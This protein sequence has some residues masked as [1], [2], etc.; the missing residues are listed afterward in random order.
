MIRRFD[1]WLAD[2]EPQRG[3]EAGKVRPVLVVQTDLLNHHHPSTIICPITTNVII[4]ADLLR[5]NVKKTG[6]GLKKQSDIMIDQVRAID[7]RRLV[8][9]LGRIDAVAQL[10]VAECLKLILDLE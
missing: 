5:V 8:K 2:L 7:N 10:K 4:G 1:I 3:T 9:R 6:S